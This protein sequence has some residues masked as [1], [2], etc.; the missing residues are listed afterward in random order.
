MI[1]A[2]EEIDAL[3]R[4]LDE[5]SMDLLARQQPVATDLRIVV[6]GLRMSAD[7]ERMGDLARHVAKLAR[8]RY[9]DS[10]V[11]AELRAT[12]LRDGPGRRADR[13]QGRQRHRQQG[14]R[15][16]AA[17][18]RRTTTRWTACTASSS[19]T[20]LDDR[21][22]YGIETAVDVTLVGPLLRAVRRPR[23]LGGH[24][25][26]STWSPASRSDAQRARLDDA[27]SR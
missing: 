10:A 7:L 9:P 15:R 12:V 1:A 16:R 11:P 21:W 6:T 22:K 23:G 4:D 25:G 24:A 19:T 27:R 18:W 2:D 3:Q 8:L 20:L 13:G 5:R 17:S 14:R 26:A